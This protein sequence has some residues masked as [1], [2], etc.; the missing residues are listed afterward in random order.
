[1]ASNYF[2]RGQEFCCT[3]PAKTYSYIRTG[4]PILAA[5]ISSELKGLLADFPQANFVAPDNIEGLAAAIRDAVGSWTPSASKEDESLP[6]SPAK[7]QQYSRET[8]AQQLGELIQ[9]LLGNS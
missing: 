9:K 8:G 2:Y 4:N 1:M 5:T 7:V 6:P 3:I